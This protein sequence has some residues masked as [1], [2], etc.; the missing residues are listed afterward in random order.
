ME[1]IMST[2]LLFTPHS[3]HNSRPQIHPTALPCSCWWEQRGQV[4]NNRGLD[5]GSSG[6]QQRTSRCNRPV[7]LLTVHNK[8]HDST[9][10]T[11]L[12]VTNFYVTV[13]WFLS[14]HPFF[15]IS[16]FLF[17]FLSLSLS[18]SL[19]LL[20]KT[21]ILPLSLPPCALLVLFNLLPCACAAPCCMWVN[22]FVS[23]PFPF[24]VCVPLY[25]CVSVLGH[26]FLS[27]D[28]NQARVCRPMIEG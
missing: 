1:H 16:F 15:F 21:L 3:I 11:E 25:V 22:E 2:E 7:V 19:S 9:R 28:S 4:C 6:S 12:S 5:L 8:N 20:F 24:C 13:V 27:S 26:S 18:P 14:L 10:K 17:L 23:P